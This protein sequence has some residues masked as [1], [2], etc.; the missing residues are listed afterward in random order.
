M[1]V[2]FWGEDGIEAKVFFPEYY[3][4]YDEIAPAHLFGRNIEGE[5]FRARQCFKEGKIELFA[6][7]GVFARACA[8]ESERTLAQMA[9]NRLRYPAELSAAKREQYENYIRSHDREIAV[10]RAK[11]RN[12]DS[13]QFLCN[14][15][16]L[17]GEA[18]TEAALACARMEW[19]Q[20]AAGLMQYKNE[21]VKEQKSRY[22]FDEF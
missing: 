3:E 15:K 14:Q 6:Y 18:V 21:M 5:G 16:L 11:E 9:E 4:S 13:L 2:A 19:A 17:S 8:D 20:G 22:E 10:L 7:D 12:L 1:E